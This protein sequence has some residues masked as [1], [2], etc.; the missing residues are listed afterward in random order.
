MTAGVLR[1]IAHT[2]ILQNVKNGKPDAKTV[3][4][5]RHSVGCWIEAEC[6]LKRKKICL[7][8]WI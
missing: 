3:H 4:R 6:F 8:D 7:Q 1:G 2:L 5:E